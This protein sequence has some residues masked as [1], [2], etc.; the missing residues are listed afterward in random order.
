M[1]LTYDQRVELLA[2]AREA[3]K[4]KM[5][6]SK[7]EPKEIVNEDSDSSSDEDNQE[8]NNTPVKFPKNKIPNPRWLKNPEKQKKIK[9][10][11]AMTKEEYLID[12]EVKPVKSVRAKKVADPEPDREPTPEPKKRAPPKKKE[13]IRSLDIIAEPKPI[14]QVMDEVVNNDVKYKA[15]AKAPAKPKNNAV[16][17]T[18]PQMPFTLFDY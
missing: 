7:S 12:D 17:I 15:R 4:Q 18:K 2:K 10:D 14:E 3:K 11:G 6:A 8:V 16:T 13:P 9:D 5:L 1:P